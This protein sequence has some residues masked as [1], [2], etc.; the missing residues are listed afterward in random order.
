MDTGSSDL[1]W[2]QCKRCF[3]QKGRLFYLKIS[4]TYKPTTRKT[5]ECKYLG[6]YSDKP[7]LRFTCVRRRVRERNVAGTGE[8]SGDASQGGVYHTPFV[9]KGHLIHMGTTRSPKETLP[10]RLSPCFLHKGIPY[11]FQGLS[12][13]VDSAMDEF[14]SGLPGDSLIFAQQCSNHNATAIAKTCH[15]VNGFDNQIFSLIK[16]FPIWKWMA[17]SDDTGASTVIFNSEG[18]AVV[19]KTFNI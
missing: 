13:A 1:T 10:L 18:A 2:T 3:K 16:S 17:K 12:L 5:K 19:L 14:F 15:A 7:P 11:S 4:P 8:G 9:I 6:E